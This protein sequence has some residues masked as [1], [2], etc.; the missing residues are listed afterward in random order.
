MTKVKKEKKPQKQN[1]FALTH[2]A[3]SFS[4]C[5]PW[6]SLQGL[7]PKPSS[8]HTLGWCS[9]HTIDKVK[10]H[11]PKKKRLIGL[12]E[13]LSEQGAVLCVCIRMCAHLWVCN[14][15][16]DLFCFSDHL[17]STVL[18]PRRTVCIVCSIWTYN[19]RK[20]KTVFLKAG[21]REAEKLKEKGLPFSA[22]RVV[23][24]S[25]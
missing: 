3:M 5:L 21:H 25:H 22:L 7:C 17:E 23:S 12:V 8:P 6:H 18:S 24:E 1:F 20:G 13:T 14:I 11:V 16:D 2:K 4:A 9:G 10:H 19:H 15:S